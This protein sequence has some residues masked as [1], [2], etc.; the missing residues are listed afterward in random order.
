MNSRIE[1]LLTKEFAC[2]SEELNGTET[3]CSIRAGICT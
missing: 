3:I 1:E 2:T